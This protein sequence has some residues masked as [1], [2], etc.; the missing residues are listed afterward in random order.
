MSQKSIIPAAIPALTGVNSAVQSFLKKRNASP[1][2]VQACQYLLERLEQRGS[3]VASMSEL[4]GQGI[5]LADDE[6]L[7]SNN[8]SSGVLV[9]QG[10]WLGFRRYFR[11]EHFIATTFFQRNAPQAG[12]IQGS[13]G[14]GADI[15]ARIGDLLP[16]REMTDEH[17]KAIAAV[18]GGR[19]LLIS[20]GPGTGK[21]T[22]LAYLLLSAVLNRLDMR[23]GLCAPTGKAAW[24]MSESL[25]GTFS[26]LDTGTLSTLDEKSREAIDKLASNR[27]KTVHR[28]LE[29]RPHS[30][31]VRYREGCPM[32][33]DLVVVDEA[34]MLDVSLLKA[35]LAALKP[36][37]Q[38]VF[39]GDA[40]QLPPVGSGAGFADLCRL[41]RRCFQPQLVELTKNYRFG[42]DSGIARVA[43][44][45]LTGNAD[46]LVRS[47]P[48]GDFQFFATGNRR[49]RK[50]GLEKWLNALPKDDRQ[51]QRFKILCATNHGPG[52][53]AETNALVQEI[54][55][56]KTMIDPMR[57]PREGLP[58][59]VLSNDY[60]R[61]VFNG[62][63]GIVHWR[64]GQWMVYFGPET[65]T[66]NRP[67]WLPLSAI[68]NWQTAYAITIHKSQGSEYPHVLTVLED[69]ETTELV[70]R[71]LL[72]TAI[73]RASHSFTLM[74]AQKTVD[75]VV[76]RQVRRETFLRYFGPDWLGCV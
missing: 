61:H 2:L 35:L 62:D 4:A 73:T 67:E 75:E 28:L 30:N 59:M 74:A 68:Q 46:L 65:G 70:D 19:H 26:G 33:Y 24:R 36:D 50:S 55:F 69:K 17:R 42:E 13:K 60:Y 66:D 41:A 31:S 54:L 53:V 37:A 25:Q 56:G 27:G 15:T 48:S 23:V 21:T 32:A 52:S 51:A 40:N 49:E 20:G 12:A 44:A 57:T 22:T 72:Y 3:T 7:V 9:R 45:V 11:H 34:S 76:G 14:K 43:Q 38:V 39:L 29:H 6:P 64:E 1:S 10:E 8:G 58:I 71:K 47:R 18:T 16:G 63:A 5:Q